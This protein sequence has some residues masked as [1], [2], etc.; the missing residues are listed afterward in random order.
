MRFVMGLLVGRVWSNWIEYVYHRWAMHWPSLYQ[1]AGMRHHAAPSDPEYITM[2][3]GFW[4]VVS[5]MNVLLSFPYS[6]GS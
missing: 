4:M 3:P 5:G 2:G 6:T 1:T